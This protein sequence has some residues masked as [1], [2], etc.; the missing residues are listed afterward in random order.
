MC[1]RVL[2]LSYLIWLALTAWALDRRREGHP[3]LG[4]RSATQSAVRAAS[5]VI[6]AAFGVIGALLLDQQDS[7]LGGAIIGALIVGSILYLT[8]VAMW[9]GTAALR[10]RSIGY[11]LLVLALF[12][13]STLTLG[14]PVAALLVVTLDQA[15]DS[16]KRPMLERRSV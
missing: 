8:G 14:L 11:L 15:P 4:T 16:P 12:V 5:A 2:F 10:V 13:P 3:L 6:G 7:A 9:R 1:P